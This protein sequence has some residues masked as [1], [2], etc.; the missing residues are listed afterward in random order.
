M[1]T[2]E[3]IGLYIHIP[4]CRSKCPYCDFYSSVG[5]EEVMDHYLAALV[6]E[7]QTLRRVSP[8]LKGP[9]PPIGTIYFGGGT[10]SL[11]GGK[12]IAC[13]LDTIASR[14]SVTE[15][16]EITVEAN[17]SSTDAA[18]LSAIHSAGAN[19][20]SL[21]L[22]SAVD[23]ERK[24]L[25]R[26]SGAKETSQ[27]IEKAIQAGFSRLSLDL[28]I[29]IPKQTPESLAK[30]LSFCLSS[31]A[32]HI[33]AYLLQIEEGTV[34]YKRRNTLSLP[35]EDTQCQ[36]YFQL[37]ETLRDAGFCHYEISNFAKPN[38]ESRHN[39]NYW[40][41]GSYLGLGAAAHSFL[42]G[43]RFYF[44]RDIQSFLDGHVPVDDG[45]GGTKEEFIL[46]SLRTKNGLDFAD[47]Q[48]RFHEKL[49]QAFFMAAKNKIPPA[50]IHLTEQSL[51]LTEKGFLLE[52]EI[53]AELL[54]AMPEEKSFHI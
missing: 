48:A 29:G 27:A 45:D 22:Q 18:F 16:P 15:N 23:A 50:C 13:L 33:S 51:S 32:G 36:L 28:M 44:P 41:C 54:S 19:R 26:Q 49:P 46:L 11:F 34:F 9:L 7:M 3:P 40:R 53:L 6:N 12:R 38:E 17:P 30:S 21:G 39:L 35:E 5:K 52:N 8:F 4:F 42:F 20:L 25:G 43:R 47:Y 31:G 10:P 2:A 24:A 37:C 14:F 1:K